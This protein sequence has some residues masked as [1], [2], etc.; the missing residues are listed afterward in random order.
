MP[1]KSLTLQDALQYV[2]EANATDLEKLAEVCHARLR[3]L[4]DIA[5]LVGLDAFKKDV[6]VQT[7][8]EIQRRYRNRLGTVLDVKVKRISVIL[9]SQYGEQ[10]DVVNFLPE[11]LEIVDAAKF[12]KPTRTRMGVPT[13]IRMPITAPKTTADFA[14]NDRVQISDTIGG[15]WSGMT[16]IIEK[17]NPK[18]ILVS[19]PIGKVNA[20]PSLLTKLP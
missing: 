17:I 6:R 7:K 8:S 10:E 11:H 15:K 18:K 14:L 5:N 20:E 16:G 4:R 13:P 3:H 1:P 2:S 12:P 19:T 9:D